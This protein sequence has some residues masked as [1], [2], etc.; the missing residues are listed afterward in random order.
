MV[1]SRKTLSKVPLLKLLIY[2]VEEQSG[3][4][5]LTKKDIYRKGEL[6]RCSQM[7][8]VEFFSTFF[9]RLCNYV[10]LDCMSKK[11]NYITWFFI[12]KYVYWLLIYY[13]SKKAKDT[14][15]PLFWF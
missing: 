2:K 5:C 11:T 1:G 12:P 10:N 6:S 14:I 7:R 13:I 8:W 3:I 15:I 9:V 4:L